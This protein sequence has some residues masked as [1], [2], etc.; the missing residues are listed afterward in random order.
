[1][2]DAALRLYVNFAVS[3]DDGFFLGLPSWHNKLTRQPDANTESCTVI[4]NDMS[5]IIQIIVNVV[6]MLIRASS[7]VAIGFILFGAFM[8]MTSQGNP[9][10]IKQGKDT[11]IGAAIGLVITVAASLVVAAGIGSIS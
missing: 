1:M 2:I 10:K 3:C 9:E 8:V 4:I 5:D 11:I 7:F 6:Q